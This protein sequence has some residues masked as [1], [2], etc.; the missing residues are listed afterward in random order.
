MRKGRPVE[1][2]AQ[3]RFAIFLWGRGEG[4]SGG[5]ISESVSSLARRWLPLKGKLGVVSGN[6]MPL[7]AQGLRPALDACA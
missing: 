6:H 5:V 4:A 1:V 7:V 3:C 2:E